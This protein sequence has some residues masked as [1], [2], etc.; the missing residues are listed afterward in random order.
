MTW[1]GGVGGNH[2]VML[3]IHH[4]KELWL[5]NLLEVVCDLTFLLRFSFPD[6]RELSTLAWSSLKKLPVVD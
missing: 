6:R 5:S 1:G 2:K 4:F 3:G